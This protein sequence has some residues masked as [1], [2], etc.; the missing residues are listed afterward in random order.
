MRKIYIIFYRDRALVSSCFH[1]MYASRIYFTEHTE[2]GPYCIVQSITATTVLIMHL[3]HL[4][5]CAALAH[6]CPSS[7]VV[8]CWKII[9][10]K[11]AQNIAYTALLLCAL[12][13]L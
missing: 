4:E 1:L 6:V 2:T 5:D 11:D 12:S 7:T 10:S 9:L 13:N 8:H 3:N